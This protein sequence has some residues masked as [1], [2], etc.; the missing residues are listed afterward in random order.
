MKRLFQAGSKSMGFEF[1]ENKA[2]AKAWAHPKGLT[3]MAGPDHW[4]H[5]NV[6][7]S[8]QPIRIRIKE[9]T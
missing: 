7:R 9:S 4:R 5:I 8:S 6:P 3:V 1:F 2:D